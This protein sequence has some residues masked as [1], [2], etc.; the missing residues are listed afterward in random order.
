MFTWKTVQAVY[1]QYQEDKGS[2]RKFFSLD[3]IFMVS[4]AA[5]LPLQEA[6]STPL[7]YSERFAAH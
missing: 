4:L 1:D 7:T 3:S 6:L 2:F 5:M